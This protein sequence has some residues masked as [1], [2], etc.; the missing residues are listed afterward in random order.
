MEFTIEV[1]GLRELNDQLEQLPVNIRDKA[2]QEALRNCT[3]IMVEAAKS[4]APVGRKVAGYHQGSRSPGQLRNA[5]VSRKAG[6]PNPW[7]VDQY[8]MVSK[9]RKA[10][11]FYAHMIEFGHK[12]I[13]IT[14]RN[15]KRTEWGYYSP[16]PFMRP[17]FEENVSR[18]IEVFR[19]TLGKRVPK[20]LKKYGA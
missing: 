7:T 3:K 10:G 16:H 20:L 12:I 11:A 18:M 1:K 19:S 15:R 5:I 8:V 6:N 17:A 14:G 9:G 2:V 13:L 4:K